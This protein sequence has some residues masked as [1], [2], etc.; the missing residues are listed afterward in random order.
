M[1]TNLTGLPGNGKTLFALWYIKALAEREGREV[2]YSGIK[3]L[4]LPWTEIEPEKWMDCPAGAIIVIDECQFVFSKKPN[5][6]VLPPHYQQLAVH[7]HSGFDIFLITQHPTL[8]DNFVRKL[9]QQHFHVVRKFGMARATVYEWSGS[10]S[11]PEKASSQKSSI[12]LK[13]AYPKS[14]YEYYKSAEVHTVQRS[15]PAK[16]ILAVLFVIAVAVG[17]FYALDRFQARG[18]KPI[19]AASASVS[20]SVGSSVRGGAGGG[21]ARVV[22]AFDPV[23]DLREYALQGTP[24]VAGL[25]HTAPKYDE[26]TAP[27]RVPVP[28]A[29]IQVADRCRCLTQQGTPMDVPHGMCV[30]FARNGWFQDFDPDGDRKQTERTKESVA[31][32]EGRNSVQDV[33]GRD[34]S[35]HNVVVFGNPGPDQPHVPAVGGGSTASAGGR[36]GQGG[37]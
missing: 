32:L 19:D 27:V 7:R 4:R 20:A 37:I 9:V 30:E 25:P 21:V 26:L 12:S 31:V 3:D 11:S 36:Q 6:A 22:D 34:S 16:L 29:C 14:V 35:S 5:G 23:V 10:N 15:I 18:R 24:R 28:A 8:V 1:I 13:W 17:G 2:F 33:S